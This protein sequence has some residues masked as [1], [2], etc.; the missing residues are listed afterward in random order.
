VAF[1]ATRLLYCI[2]GCSREHGIFDSL[3]LCLANAERICRS[4]DLL[5]HSSC[6]DGKHEVSQF[7]GA[8]LCNDLRCDCS[9]W[10]RPFRLGWLA[11]A[12]LLKYVSSSTGSAHEQLDDSHEWTHIDPLTMV[13]LT[14]PVVLVV[15]LPFNRLSWSPEILSRLFL[16][17]YELMLSGMLAFSLQVVNAITIYQLSATGLALATVVKNV[18]IVVS[19]VI[20]LDES[21]T[22]VQIAAFSGAIFGVALYSAMKLFPGWFDRFNSSAVA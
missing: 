1:P 2:C 16:F 19:A 22:L 9:R 13:L 15:L 21:L 14:A 11:L 20:I 4:D 7:D 10:R 5:A 17:K 8:H 6:W 3:S 12:G 18:M